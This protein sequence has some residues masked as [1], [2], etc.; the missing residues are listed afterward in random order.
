MEILYFF[1]TFSW[2]GKLRGPLALGHS[3]N[4]LFLSKWGITVK[5][6]KKY[7]LRSDTKYIDILNEPV[8]N[9]HYYFDLIKVKITYFYNLIFK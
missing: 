2:L 5:F 3:R 8:K 1:A 6:F 9:S 4:K 7:Y